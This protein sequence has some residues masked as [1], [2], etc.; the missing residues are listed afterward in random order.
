M[1]FKNPRSPLL[2][3]FIVAVNALSFWLLSGLSGNTQ[4]YLRNLL[5]SE[6]VSDA[7]I[8]N[9]QSLETHLMADFKTDTGTQAS[10][11]SYINQDK[12]KSLRQLQQAGTSTDRMAVAVAATIGPSPNGSY[13][14]KHPTYA[15]VQGVEHG[16]GCCSDYSKAFLVYAAHLGI[17]VREVYVLSHATVEYFNPEQHRWIW[18]D[19]YFSTQVTDQGGKLL[20][21]YQIRMASRFQD[22]RLLDHPPSVTTIPAFEGFRGYDTRHYDVLLYKKGNNFFELEALHRHLQWLRLPKSILQLSSY[23]LGAQ[24]GYLMLTTEGMAVYMNTLK[25]MMWSVAQLWLGTN[26][27]L[28]GLL[29]YWEG[30]SRSRAMVATK[31]A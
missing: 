4:V 16:Q 11:A 26:A 14:G 31:S 29:V 22:L 9:E 12:L 8:A 10:Q 3:V 18:F 24:P 1:L 5:F 23:F 7:R 21:L 2:L 6:I 15:L 30:R 28:L 17:Q 19:P 27:L 13:C 25:N 20:S